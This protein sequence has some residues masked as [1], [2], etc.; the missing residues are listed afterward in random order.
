MVQEIW[1]GTLKAW[2]DAFLRER[3]ALSGFP[4][5]KEENKHVLK[6]RKYET[7]NGG[8]GGE[9]WML[10]VVCYLF[11]GAHAKHFPPPLPSLDTSEKEG[12]GGGG[13]EKLLLYPHC[14]FLSFSLPL[15]VGVS[16]S[17]RDMYVVHTCIYANTLLHG[18]SEGN[19]SQHDDG[20]D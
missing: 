5:K 18:C 15:S 19:R 6:A 12:R 10:D 14:C 3:L 4:K 17:A 2:V 13:G 11:F 20:M 1:M 8:G 16:L 9:C 7:K